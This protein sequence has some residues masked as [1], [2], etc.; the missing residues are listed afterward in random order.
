MWQRRRN[1]RA[2]IRIIDKDK[3]NQE[4]KYENLLNGVVTEQLKIAKIFEENLKIFDK[5]KKG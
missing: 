5:I 3:E 1:T 4:F 2:Y